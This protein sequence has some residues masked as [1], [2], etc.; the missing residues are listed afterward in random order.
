MSSKIKHIIALSFWSI[1]ISVF[2][3]LT[4]I[5]FNK[6]GT[7]R[8][9]DIF[10]LSIALYNLLIL[11]TWGIREKSQVDD[12]LD[13]HIKTRSSR[14]SY[15]ILMFSSVA[16]YYFFSDKDNYPL[17]AVI[18]IIF[19]AKPLLEFIYSRRFK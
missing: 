5:N 3:L 19:I 15:L 7:I 9:F 6:Y 4:I 10:I 16:I 12:E 18:A 11:L 13:T 17:I 2:A 8:G 1:G 14:L